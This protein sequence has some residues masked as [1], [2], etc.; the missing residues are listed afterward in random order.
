MPRGAILWKRVCGRSQAVE[1]ILAILVRLELAAEIVVGLIFRILEVVLAVAASLPHVE[2][3][4]WNGLL[5]LEVADDAMH[6]SDH[7]LV[8][9]LDDAVTKI[10]PRRIRRPERAKNGCRGGYVV[11]VL[12]LDVVRNFRHKRFETSDVR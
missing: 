6:V 10:P 2:S 9:I 12:R 4:I 1:A 11:G 8:L 3:Y 7:P 5:C